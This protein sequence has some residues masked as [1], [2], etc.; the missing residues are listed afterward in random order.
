ML[1]VLMMRITDD[2]NFTT[3]MMTMT[4]RTM[5]DG[6][7]AL[8]SM[9]M[10]RGR[11]NHDCICRVIYYDND[12]T[13]HDDDD[14]TNEADADERS[15]AKARKEHELDFCSNLRLYYTQKQIILTSSALFCVPT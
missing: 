9:I 2:Y 1:L 5:Q 4:I 13:E 6:G 15:V 11:S 12:P 10:V 3:M 7:G 8:Y 14:D